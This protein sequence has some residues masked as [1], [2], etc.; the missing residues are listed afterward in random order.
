MKRTAE[1]PEPPQPSARDDGAP[2]VR[3][4]AVGERGL[5]RGAPPAARAPGV[6]PPLPAPGRIGARGAAQTSSERS[7][8]AALQERIWS[9]LASQTGAHESV[10]A[11]RSG[12]APQAPAPA[13]PPEVGLRLVSTASSGAVP[14]P[15]ASRAVA[16]SPRASGSY[17]SASGQGDVAIPRAAPAPAGAAPVPSAEMPL[18]YVIAS[19]FFLA[20]AVVGFGLWLAFEVV[21]L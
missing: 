8:E 11:Q 10:Q 9:G 12:L 19:G 7:L 14:S 21:S 5:Q 17:P 1:P 18:G 13:P 4:A 15:P 20:I 2:P 3:E 16:P 6:P